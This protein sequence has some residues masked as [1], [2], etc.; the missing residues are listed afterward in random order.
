MVKLQDYLSLN[1]VPHYQSVREYLV[2]GLKPVG[3]VSVC[4]TVTERNLQEVN[5]QPAVS[6]RL[7]N[8]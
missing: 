1:D 4:L 7:L 3:G 6:D 5:L 2:V 8:P